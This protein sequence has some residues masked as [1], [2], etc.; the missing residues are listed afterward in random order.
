[1]KPKSKSKVIRNVDDMEATNQSISFGNGG[2][3]NH[4][5]ITNLLVDQTAQRLAHTQTFD[6]NGGQVNLFEY[7]T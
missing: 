1:M 2:C 4:Q 6:L 3:I 7:S 5:R